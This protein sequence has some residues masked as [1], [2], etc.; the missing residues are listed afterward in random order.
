MNERGKYIVIEGADA[1]GKS[2]H[3]NGISERLR[4]LGM[5]TLLVLNDDTN[6]MEPIQEPG[7]VPT[8]NELRKIIK[9]GNLERDPWTNVMLFTA[10]RRLNWIQAMEPALDKGM[11]VVT[12]RSWISTVTY[13]GYG[14]GIDIDAIAERTRQDVGDVYMNPDL[15]VILTVAD[16]AARKSMMEQRGASLHPDTFESKPI[17]FQ[18]NMKDGYVKFAHHKNLPVLP[19]NVWPHM[20]PEEIAHSKK[21]VSDRIWHHVEKLL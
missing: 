11:Y 20:S 8:A 18:E 14:E 4:A 12:A 5:Q 3:A 7:G 9:N 2:E 16:E 15:E 19:V 1:T 21:D 6:R 10:A 17:E 13:Q